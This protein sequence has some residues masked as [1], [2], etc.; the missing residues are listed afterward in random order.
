MFDVGRIYGGRMC[1]VV[2]IYRWILFYV[3]DICMDIGHHLSIQQT[4]IHTPISSTSLSIK[5][6]FFN[7][8]SLV[9]PPAV[10]LVVSSVCSQTT[11]T[12]ARFTSSDQKSIPSS[13]HNDIHTS[14]DSGRSSQ[15]E[16][17]GQ[18]PPYRGS[19]SGKQAAER[20]DSLILV[21][22]TDLPPSSSTSTQRLCSYANECQEFL[23]ILQIPG[24]EHSF[25]HFCCWR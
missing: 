13:D 7:A 12:S 2:T 18:Y 6:G 19:N 9:Q 21:L 15:T 23:K 4:C 24:G 5:S 1:N 17:T 10:Q 11:Q 22:S 3:K 25:D 14:A 16:Y 8:G 20:A